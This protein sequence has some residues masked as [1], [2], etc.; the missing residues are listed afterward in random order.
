M[1]TPRWPAGT[2][3]TDSPS[4]S[5]SPRVHSSRPQM[6]RSSVDFPHPEGP[7]SA[8]NSPSS[9]RRSTPGMASKSPNVLPTSFSSILVT[10]GLHG[11]GRQPAP[12]GLEQRRIAGVARRVRFAVRGSAAGLLAGIDEAGFPFRRGLPRR[13]PCRGRDRWSPRSRERRR[14]F[15]SKRE[16]A[17]RRRPDAHGSASAGRRPTKRRQAQ[18]P[19]PRTPP[20]PCAR[21]RAGR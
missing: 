15:R 16:C 1:A 4:I 7:T 2:P 6:M 19:C 17:C 8:T 10:V 5:T 18:R 9:M 21:G 20:A 13:T 11:V 12:V 3:S 14:R